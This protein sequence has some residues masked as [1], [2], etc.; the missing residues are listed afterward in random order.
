MLLC[1]Q[2]FAFR[3][4]VYH[5]NQLEFRLWSLV[6]ALVWKLTAR[7]Y[8]H[9]D[10][11]CPK[12][13]KKDKLQSKSSLGKGQFIFKLGY[14][15]TFNTDIRYTDKDIVMILNSPLKTHDY[16]TYKRAWHRGHS[17]NY[18][19]SRA[20]QN[21]NL[22]WSNNKIG[23]THCLNFETCFKKR[24]KHIIF[25]SFP[26]VIF[27]IEDLFQCNFMRIQLRILF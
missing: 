10:T 5:S 13:I 24:P 4:A 15:S 12:H 17:K 27:V 23:V 16:L 2:R 20:D 21:Q 9:P 18:K 8:Y 19:I 11:D 7:C 14:Y 6:L 1:P 3:P 25:A 26:I 22:Q